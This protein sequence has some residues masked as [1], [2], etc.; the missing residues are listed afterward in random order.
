MDPHINLR[1]RL[2]MLD[3]VGDAGQQRAAAHRHQHGVHR[4]QLL[5]HLQPHCS[6]ALDHADVVVSA[7]KILLVV[8]LLK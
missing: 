1:V 8:Y 3:G 7:G 4:G 6:L 2:E 5:H